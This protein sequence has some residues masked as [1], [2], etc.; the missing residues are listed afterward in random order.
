M[1]ALA[2]ALGGAAG[3]LL[4]Y[5]LAVSVQYRLVTN[6]PWGTLV[7]NVIGSLLIGVLYILLQTRLQENEPL[8][9]LLMVGLLGG[10]TTFSSF[11]IETLQL[12]QT[13]F[14]LKAVSNILASVGACLLAAFAG[15]LVGR[16]LSA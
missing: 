1:N 7:V 11:S 10:F 3:S 14:W 13:G 9:L 5:W 8:R 2:I 12:F 15:M 16:L 6:F 4:R